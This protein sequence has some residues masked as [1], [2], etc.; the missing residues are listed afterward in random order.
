MVMK[1]TWL[2][3]SSLI[4]CLKN[5]EAQIHRTSGDVD[6]ADFVNHWYNMFNILLEKALL[7]TSP[8][9]CLDTNNVNLSE[10]EW[11]M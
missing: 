3:A 2:L 6:V 10:E 1:I 7:P 11:N 8:S 9:R 4:I 5:S